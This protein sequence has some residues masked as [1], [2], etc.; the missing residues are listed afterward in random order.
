MTIPVDKPILTCYGIPMTTNE[1]I[2]KAKSRTISL[3]GKIS[4]QDLIVSM[5]SILLLEGFSVKEC[6]R[7]MDEASK[8]VDMD[9]DDIDVE[10]GEDW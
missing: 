9:D 5:W 1:L 6:E 7:L 4:S 3:Y 10:Y 2:E 8:M